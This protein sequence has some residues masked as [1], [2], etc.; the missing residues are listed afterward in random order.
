MN[1]ATNPM[2]MAPRKSLT[3]RQ[4]QK[5]GFR[6]RGKARSSDHAERDETRER[7]V[8]ASERSRCKAGEVPGLRVVLRIAVARTWCYSEFAY[9][10]A[11]NWRAW[12]RTPWHLA[13]PRISFSE[14]NQNAR[15]DCPP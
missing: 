2:A 13:W 10:R 8:E 14:V 7:D 11:F 1:E 12:R 9:H 5:S 15:R 4:I 6:R 3:V